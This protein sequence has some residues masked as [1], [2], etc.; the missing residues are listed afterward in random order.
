L[1]KADRWPVAW[2]YASLRHMAVIV[3]CKYVRGQ[4]LSVAGTSAAGPSG[5]SNTPWQ[6]RPRTV[7]VRGRYVRG[8]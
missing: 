4:S 1:K 6:V 7:T 3:R 8:Q 5:E 2:A